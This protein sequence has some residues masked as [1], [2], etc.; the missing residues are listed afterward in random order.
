MI[1]YLRHFL[2]FIFSFYPHFYPHDL[3]ATWLNKSQRLAHVFLLKDAQWFDNQHCASYPPH[4]IPASQTPPYPHPPIF[5]LGTICHKLHSNLD[6]R[7]NSIAILMTSAAAHFSF[8][9][10]PETSIIH[11]VITRL[12]SARFFRLITLV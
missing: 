12:F 11:Q 3:V 1:V 5:D 9:T 2:D 7:L 8:V 4:Q 6:E 10:L